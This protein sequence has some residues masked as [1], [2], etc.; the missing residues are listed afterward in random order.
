MKKHIK[1][2]V[3]I[4]AIIGI[5]IVL[6]LTPLGKSL[7]INKIYENKDTLIELVNSRMI[8]SVIIYISVY[9]LSVSL[10][11]PGA[12]LLSIMGGFLFG[13]LFG[14]I[15]I[16][17]GATTGAVII[18]IVSRYILGKSLQDRY[19]VQLTK[20]NK[21]LE[22][23]G[24]NYMLTLRLIPIF[25][26]FLINILAGLTN[27]DV[28]K[29]IWTT[30]L[31]IIPGSFIYCYLGYAG[32]TVADGEGFFTKEIIFA[33]LLLGLIS[34]LPVLIKKISSRNV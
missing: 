6:K 11:I 20:F 3:I 7:D 4:L 17:L 23:N 15:Y 14:T 30:S 21:E 26:F 28:K 22:E 18:F 33:L 29:F 16:N 8:L 19:S 5:I 1:K 27:I 13:P 32:T 10:S 24:T 2:A 34:L 9:I 12:S 25:P 31:G